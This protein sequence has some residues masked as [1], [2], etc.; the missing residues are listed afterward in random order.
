MRFERAV[1]QLA[2]LR[3]VPDKEVL[4]N[5]EIWKDVAHALFNLK[6]FIFIP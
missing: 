5:Q 1:A 4:T 3:G 2:G 6:E